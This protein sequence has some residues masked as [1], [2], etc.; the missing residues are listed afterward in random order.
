MTN[1]VEYPEGYIFPNK[2]W[3]VIREV[4][5]KGKD[6]Y[7]LCECLLCNKEY[8]VALTSLKNKNT[9][10]CCRGC[11]K[12]KWS[13]T[14][15][16]EL[17]G[18]T[19]GRLIVISKYSQN[20]HGQWQYLCKCEC[21][22]EKVILGYSFKNSKTI[23]CGCYQKQIVSETQSGANSHFWIDGRT[24]Q[25]ELDRTKIRESI[26]PKIRERDDYTC[27]NC[28][29]NKGGTLECHHIFDFATYPDLR[30]EESNLITL[31][32]DC[33]KD[34]HKIYPKYFS[35][36]LIDLEKYLGHEYKY[37]QQLQDLLIKNNI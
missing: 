6:R 30:F 24:Q 21:G 28:G 23:S 15:A 3:R 4:D 35:N 20:K 18:K 27:Q 13:E 34:F 19:F 33:H 8:E 17:V 5:K 37:H 32:I 2:Q 29:D 1:K 31:C 36:T 9:S 16:E 7:F 26:N 22:T 14:N 11:S 12:S 10:F 25:N